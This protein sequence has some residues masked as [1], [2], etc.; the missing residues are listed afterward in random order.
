MYNSN[1]VFIDSV[2]NYFTRESHWNC[3][4]GFCQRLRINTKLNV[5]K[6]L[7]YKQAERVEFLLGQVVEKKANKLNFSGPSAQVKPAPSSKKSKEF[8]KRMVV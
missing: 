2:A 3:G 6:A 8:V 1:F 4:I 7:R 5:N